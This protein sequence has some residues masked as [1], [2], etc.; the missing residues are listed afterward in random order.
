[1][2][3]T[4]EIEAAAFLRKMGMALRYNATSG[5]PLASMYAVVAD[6]RRAVELTNALL[7]AGEAVETNVIAGRLVLVHRDLVPALYVL[8]LRFRSPELSANAARVLELIEEDGS[9]TAGDAR[10]FLGVAGTE[11]PDPADI[12]LTELQRDMLVDRGPSSVPKSGM[13]YLSKEGYPYRI[14]ERAHSD[15]VKAAK[16]MKID[17]AVRRLRFAAGPIPPRKFLSMFKLCIT[18][19]DLE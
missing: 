2:P 1:M 11:R 4:S 15:L 19:A 16:T 17:D 14:F 7:A 8:R 3:I 9:A 18:E 5:L 10:R 12:A 13:P 6:P